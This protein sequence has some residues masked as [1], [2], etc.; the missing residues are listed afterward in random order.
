MTTN[1][2]GSTCYDFVIRNVRLLTTGKGTNSQLGRNRIFI[3]F[4]QAPTDRPLDYGDLRMAC[5]DTRYVNS[6]VKAP[7]SGVVHLD[8]I[9]LVAPTQLNPA[10][11][12]ID[13][14]GQ[15]TV[16]DGGT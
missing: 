10:T 13:L 9:Q 12:C 2:D 7:A 8:D 16:G 15:V 4:D 6:A 11:D 14:T 5:I 3:T 1:L